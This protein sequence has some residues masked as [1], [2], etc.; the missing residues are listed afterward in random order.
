ME[1]A[2]A[3]IHYIQKIKKCAVL[4]LMTNALDVMMDLSNAVKQ[5]FYFQ[6]RRFKRGEIYKI[7]IILTYIAKCKNDKMDGD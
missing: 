2:P 7:L 5:F 6:K 4:A 1:N 3:Q